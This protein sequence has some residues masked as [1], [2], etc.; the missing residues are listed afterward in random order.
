MKE[1]SQIKMKE[2]IDKQLTAEIS[3]LLKFQ[4]SEICDKLMESF[5]AIYDGPVH[6]IAELRA[7]LSRKSRGDIFEHFALRYFKVCLGYKSWLLED[8]PDEL[9]R[10]LKLKRRD[11][12]ID[13]IAVDDLGR[14]YAIQAKFRKRSKRRKT[15]GVSWR[16]LSTFY[17]LASRSGPYH[18]H[19]VFTNADYVRHAG[20]RTPEDKSICIGTLRGISKGSW[21]E[22]VDGK[23]VSTPGAV[24]LSQ[25]DLRNAR[26]RFFST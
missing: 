7:S 21:C 11:M 16:Q 14:A 12:G 3:K 26:L 19:V 15:F 18:K 5:E 20:N 24:G 22:L 9:L 13:L 1:Y 6:S 8:V 23:R 17:A 2:D 4:G 10:K 25:E